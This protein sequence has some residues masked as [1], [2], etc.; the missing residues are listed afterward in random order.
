MLSRASVSVPVSLYVSCL[1]YV[2]VSVSVLCLC[3]CP[4]LCDGEDDR[5]TR[6]EADVREPAR[7]GRRRTSRRRMDDSRGEGAK[8]GRDNSGGVGSA[9][10]GGGDNHGCGGEEDRP[11]DVAAAELTE[12]E[13]PLC[14]ATGLLVPVRLRLCGPTLALTREKNF[15]ALSA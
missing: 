1:C 12:M 8:D 3:I 9:E 2:N 14:S 10:G 4:G 6:R 11:G 15:L 7:G 5:G 13:E